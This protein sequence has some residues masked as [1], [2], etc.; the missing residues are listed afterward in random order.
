MRLSTTCCSKRVSVDSAPRSRY[1]V[2][3]SLTHVVLADTNTTTTIERY[4]ATNNRIIFRILRTRTSQ[5][6]SIW[7]LIPYRQRRTME[8]NTAPHRRIRNSAHEPR[9]STPMCSRAVSRNN[10]SAL[11]KSANFTA[12]KRSRIWRN[13]Q[14][15]RSGVCLNKV[16]LPATITNTE[17]RKCP[18]NLTS[19]RRNRK[20][21]PHI[22]RGNREVRT[23]RLRSWEIERFVCIRKRSL[24]YRLQ[25]PQMVVPLPLQIGLNRIRADE[26]RDKGCA[27]ESHYCFAPIWN[28]PSFSS[29]ATISIK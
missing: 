19:G 7:P 18:S 23:L 25:K 12:L 11:C 27:L 28:M 14:R 21:L 2:I 9:T 17:R 29:S 22:G 24:K 26:A 16:T 6:L 3:R 10:P 15:I 13:K 8:F 20:R 5:R 4:S 1:S